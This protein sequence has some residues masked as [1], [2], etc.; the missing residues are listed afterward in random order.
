MDLKQTLLAKF[1]ETFANVP[2]PKHFVAGYEL[3]L[4]WAEHD[5]LLRARMPETLK[6]EDVDNTCWTPIDSLSP[7]GFRYWLPAF[8][9]LAFLPEGGEFLCDLFSAHL[10][11]R[12][13][14]QFTALTAPEARLTLEVIQTVREHMRDALDEWY[15]SDKEM[16][17]VEQFWQQKVNE[18]EANETKGRDKRRRRK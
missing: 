6:L 9:R 15:V 18:L 8:V 1:D 5:D 4:E 12:R 16:A 7:E 17:Q 2:R 3:G 11:A 10:S 14:E 13:A